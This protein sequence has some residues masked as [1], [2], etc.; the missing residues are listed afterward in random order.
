MLWWENVLKPAWDVLVNAASWIWEDVIVPGWKALQNVGIWLWENIIKPSW[1][2][3]SGVGLWIW[4]QILKPAW[5]WFTGVGEKIWN[6][7][8]KP[9][10]EWFTGVGEKIWGLIKGGFQ[11][12]VDTIVDWVSNLPIIGNFVDGSRAFGGVIPKDGLYRMHA[13]ET[14]GRGNSVSTNNTTNMSPTINI[15]VSGSVDRRTINELSRRMRQELQSVSR[16]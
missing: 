10:W 11:F 3:L 9:A 13:G 1:E 6:D 12:L 4:E 2:W 5:D 7:I 14:V 16:L 15:N 8:L